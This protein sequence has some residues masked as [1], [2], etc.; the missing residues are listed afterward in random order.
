MFKTQ[1]LYQNK[2]EWKNVKLGDS[3]ETIGEWGGLL[4]S[5]TMM[6]N[7]IGYNETPCSQP[8]AVH[9]AQLPIYGYDAL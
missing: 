8:F 5:I 2:N 6:L 1:N 7:G 9:L 4:T 3:P